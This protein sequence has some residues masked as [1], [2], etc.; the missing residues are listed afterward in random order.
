MIDLHSYDLENFFDVGVASQ[1]QQPQ[2]ARQAVEYRRALIVQ[3]V[4]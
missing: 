2:M 3:S 4:G 1:L